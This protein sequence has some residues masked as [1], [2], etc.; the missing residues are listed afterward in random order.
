MTAHRIRICNIKLKRR[1]GPITDAR[2]KA[3][4]A[5]TAALM[6]AVAGRAG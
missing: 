1:V 3:K 4:I 6:R 5:T 2:R